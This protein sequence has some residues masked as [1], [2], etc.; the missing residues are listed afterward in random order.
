LLQLATLIVVLLSIFMLKEKEH[1]WQKIVATLIVV[2]GAVI[3][4]L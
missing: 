3:V 2:I 1:F 4:G